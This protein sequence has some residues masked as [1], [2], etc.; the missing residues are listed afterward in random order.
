MKLL[1]YSYLGANSDTFS[2]VKKN[3]DFILTNGY[4][5]SLERRDTMKYR[6]LP[7]F[8]VLA[9][10]FLSFWPH[11]A[12]TSSAGTTA[13]LTFSHISATGG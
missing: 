9:S 2:L 13:I 5:I 3:F 12:A 4:G 11:N 10:L 7:L 8:L 1:K 6:N